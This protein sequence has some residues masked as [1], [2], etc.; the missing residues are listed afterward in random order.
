MDVRRGDL[1]VR[2]L[3]T[4]N[5]GM[6]GR[7]LVPM[8][9][10]EGYAVDCTAADNLDI[11]QEN[12]IREV[13]D[14]CRPNFIIN[15]AAYTA[16]DRAESEKDR[17]FKVNR[18]GAGFLAKACAEFKL[19]M[20]HMS[21]DYVFDGSKRRPYLEDDPV[22]PLNTYGLSKWEGEQAI[23][24]CL[25]EHIILRT[26]WLFGAYGENFVKTILRLADDRDTLRVVADQEGCPT[27]TGDVSYGLTRLVRE[28]SLNR[29]SVPWGTYHFCGKSHTTW[30]DFAISVLEEAGKRGQL[31]ATRIIP[32][33][34][35]DY[36]TAAKRPAWSV[37]DCSKIQRTFAI[38]PRPWLEGLQNVLDTLK[39]EIFT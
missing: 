15:C 2:I 8:L 5:K 27:W 30:Y 32:I 18:D 11:T 39:F 17:A 28:I 7:D 33:R 6:L 1:P 24:S 35:S 21:T 12:Q 26:S 19:P 9:E 36:P 31:K 37:L 38:H 34:T 14:S 22:K 3:V 25:E 23:R 4:G 16:V 20:I 29:K 10:R 13:I